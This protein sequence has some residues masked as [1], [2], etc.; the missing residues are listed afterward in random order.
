MMLAWLQ[1]QYEAMGL[2]PGGPNGQW[3]QP[4]ELKRYTP[5]AGRDGQ[6]DRPGRRGARR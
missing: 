2:E 1:A 4:V 5:V 6:L 3:L